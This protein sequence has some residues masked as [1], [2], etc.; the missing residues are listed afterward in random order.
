MRSLLFLL[1]HLLTTLARRLGPGGIKSVLAE[2]LLLKQQLLVM[3]RSRRRAPALSPMDRFCLG[4]LSLCITPRRLLRAAV[5]IKS[6]TLLRFHH[7]LLKRK[8]RLLFSSRHGDKPG[9]QGPSA[10][11]IS[12]IVAIKQ[13]NPRFGCPRIALITTSTFGMER[14]DWWLVA[15][16]LAWLGGIRL[17]YK[18]R[19]TKS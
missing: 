6:S 8:Y 2:N 7:A 1:I 5:V 16:F 19:L 18:R 14:G 3:S 11:L 12:A 4:W 15:G 13:R 9:A 17:R 10:E